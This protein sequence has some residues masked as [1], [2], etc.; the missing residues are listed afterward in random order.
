MGTGTGTR[1]G[2]G[3][4]RVGNQGM[5]I[6]GWDYHGKEARGLSESGKQG[7]GRKRGIREGR[8]KGIR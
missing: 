8:R 6:E 3:E 5:K 1:E 7:S 4:G 2:T